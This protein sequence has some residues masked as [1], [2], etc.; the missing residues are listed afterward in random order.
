MKRRRPA[1]TAR[2]ARPA[3]T[4]EPRATASTATTSARRHV[5]RPDLPTLPVDGEGTKI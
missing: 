3:T 5:V 1:R 2:P 4:A